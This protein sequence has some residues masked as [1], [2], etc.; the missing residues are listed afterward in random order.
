[1][2]TANKARRGFFSKALRL[3]AIAVVIGFAVAFLFG[4]AIKGYSQAGSAFAA[5]TTC[6]CRYVAERELNS[7]E[8]DLPS[9]MWAV[10]LSEDTDAKAVTA[11]VPLIASDRATYRE[12]YGCVLDSLQD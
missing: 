8:S 3:L 6:S 9:N 10:W 7:C 12:G 5:K 4:D 1:M 11:R 2:A